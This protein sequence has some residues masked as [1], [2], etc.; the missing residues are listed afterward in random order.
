MHVALAIELLQ[1]TSP[2]TWEVMLEI[3]RT[4]VGLGANRWEQQGGDS[5]RVWV[6]LTNTGQ[7]TASR[8]RCTL[9][10]ALDDTGIVAISPAAIAAAAIEPGAQGE[11]GP[12]TVTWAPGTTGKLNLKTP[13]RFG[14][15]MFTKQIKYCKK[16]QVILSSE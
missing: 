2:L 4:R 14:E 1:T 3:G 11:V 9:T 5:A 15:R 10:P 12:F 7:A 6:G 13:I 8:L 16:K